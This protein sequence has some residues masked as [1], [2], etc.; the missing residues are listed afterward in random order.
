MLRRDFLRRSARTLGAALLTKT[1]V[2]R[3]ALLDPDPLPQKFNAQDEVV[4][5]HTGIRT[6]R[7]AMGTGTIGFGAAPTRRDWAPLLS[8]TFSSTVSTRMV[9]ASSTQRTLTAA[10]RTLPQP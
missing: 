4:L 5:G 3:A 10:I 6:S 8:P 2:A 7:L 1:A 9:C